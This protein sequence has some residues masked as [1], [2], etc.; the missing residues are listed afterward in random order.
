MKNSDAIIIGAGPAGLACA[1]SMGALGLNATVLEKGNAVGPVW[2]RH[3]DRLHLHTDRGHSGLPGMDMP[4]TYPTYP[5]RAQVVEYLEGYAAQF[6]IQ[7]VFNT[8]VRKVGRNGSLW[9]VETGQTSLSAPVVVMAT[10]WADFPYCPAWPGSDIFRGSCIHS[11]EYR[12]TSPYTGKRV[13]VVGFGNSGGEIALELA[14]A[15][16]DTTLA[17][18]GPVQILPRDLLGIPILSW[19][20][21]Q[22]SLPTSVVDFINAP[23]IRL[24]IGP[25]ER[26]GLKRAAKGP[27]RMIEEDGRI[28]LLDIGTLAKIRD[29]SI[30][31]RGGIDRFMAD[32]VIFSDQG[33]QK[34][35]AI[36]LAT[37]FRPDLRQLLPDADGVLSEEGKPV[38]TG[39]ATKQP[40]LY[41]CGLVAS[42]TGQLREIGL[43]AK[44]IAGLAKNYIGLKA[45][46]AAGA[47][48]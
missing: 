27:R 9:S 10:G 44:R 2:R 39:Q 45:P 22:K 5:S 12:N 4:R 17:V 35:D 42:P 41:F 33:E 43:E 48:T 25:I 15:H 30:K 31:V 21:A 18:R 6:G 32:G 1:A 7:P 38:V 20:I 37:G 46:S 11:S 24:A 34:F 8:T 47:P 28:P 40:G 13:L 23:V 14:M 36:I 26:F 3:Y 16:I 29:G 19:A